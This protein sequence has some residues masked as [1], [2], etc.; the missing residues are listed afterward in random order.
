MLEAAY[1]TADTQ[2]RPF[3]WRG[4]VS[5]VVIAALL[6]ATLAAAA[7]YAGG[8][9]WRRLAPAAAGLAVTWW[10]AWRSLHRTVADWQRHFGKSVE[11]VA[12]RKREDEAGLRFEAP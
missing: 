12:R 10:W 8:T 9:A 5:V 6:G 4:V 2:P 11:Y 1:Q 7:T 3:P